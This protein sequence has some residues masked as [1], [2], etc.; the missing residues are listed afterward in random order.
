MAWKAENIERNM[1]ILALRRD[2]LTL[3]AIGKEVGLCG[4]AVWHILRQHERQAKGKGRPYYALGPKG[5]PCA[6]GY[7]IGRHGVA[8]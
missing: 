5:E 4:Q 7:R 6:I 8:V 2:G 1:R 3:R